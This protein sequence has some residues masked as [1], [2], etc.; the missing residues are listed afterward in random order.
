[1]GMRMG[2]TGT[3]PAGSSRPNTREFYLE[4]R[5]FFFILT[6]ERNLIKKKNDELI[7]E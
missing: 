7:N 4:T 1:M 2:R 5:R 3:F 6:P